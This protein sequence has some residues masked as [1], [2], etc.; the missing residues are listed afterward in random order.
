MWNLYFNVTKCKE[1]KSKEADYK[2]KDNDDEYRGIAKCNEEKDMGIIF[3]KSFSFDVHVQSCINKANKMIDII[4][5]TFTFLDKENFN[6]PYKT[7]LRPY[8]EYGNVI[9]S[10]YLKRQSVTSERVQRRATTLNYTQ[11]LKKLD[12]PT[13][14]YRRLGDDLVEVY[15]IINQIDDLKVDTFFTPT[16]L[17]ITRNAEYKLYVE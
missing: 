11:R 17:N 10:S 1:R 7:L 4:K 2:M 13:L 3:D 14:K 6:T 9:W 12:L 5:R 8:L 16:K 15:K